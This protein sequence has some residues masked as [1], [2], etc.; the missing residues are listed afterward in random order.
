MLIDS[1][2]SLQNHY[3]VAEQGVLHE[4]RTDYDCSSGEPTVSCY[5]FRSTW[6]VPVDSRGHDCNHTFPTQEWYLH[7]TSKCVLPCGVVPPQC[8]D[9]WLRRTGWWLPDELHTDGVVQGHSSPSRNLTVKSTL[10]PWSTFS[11]HDVYECCFAQRSA[12][13]LSITLS[14]RS[15][16]PSGSDCFPNWSDLN[17]CSG[18]DSTGTFHHFSTFCWA[19]PIFHTLY[20]VSQPPLSYSTK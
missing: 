15:L 13:L 8:S 17:Y 3:L 9:G 14:T 19:G 16:S 12:L 11:P 18:L 10:Q 1:D 7:W 5:D 20:T 2:S 6:L 4:R